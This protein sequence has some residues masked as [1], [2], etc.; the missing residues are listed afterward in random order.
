MVACELLDEEYGRDRIPKVN[1]QSD[2]NS[3]KFGRI[4]GH[5]VVIACL[6]KGRYGITSAVTVAERM[7]SS[8]P[9]IRFRLMVGIAPSQKHDVRLGDIGKTQL[10][11]EFMRQ[12][13]T[14]FSAVFW[15]DGSSNS[16]VA[17]LLA[18]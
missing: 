14:K 9:A 17:T 13:Y 15:L 16:S 1:T 2:S 7:L 10:A 11:I 8:F 6:P 12:H 4:H 18:D 3:Y 5:N